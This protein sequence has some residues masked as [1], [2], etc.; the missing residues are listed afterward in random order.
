MLRRYGIASAALIVS[1]LL[2]VSTAFPHAQLVR[3][4]PPVDGSVASSPRE[5]S[6]YFSENI[7]AANSTITVQDAA[8]ARVDDGNARLDSGNRRVLRVAI[9]PLPTGTYKVI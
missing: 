7:V 4:S 1:F 3:A 6:I 5:V 9:K 2:G 8:G